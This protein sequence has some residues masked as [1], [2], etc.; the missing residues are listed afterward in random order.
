MNQAKHRTK[1]QALHIVRAAGATALGSGLERA[2][3]RL[4]RVGWVSGFEP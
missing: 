2:R 3:D 4:D 1:G